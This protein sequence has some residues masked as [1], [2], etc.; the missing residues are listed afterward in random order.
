MK[1]TS[2]RW[3][4]WLL[5]AVMLLT[6]IPTVAVT[7]SAASS[8]SCGTGV[9]YTLDDAGL[10]TISGAGTVSGTIFQHNT[11]IKRIVIKSGV[12]GI[13][14]RVFLGC[15]NLETV[16]IPASV[17]T[18]GLRAFDLEGGSKLKAVN[19]AGNANLTIAG[20]AFE[21]IAS[22]YTVTYLNTL[23]PQFVGTN[24]FGSNATVYLRTDYDGTSFS[25]ATVKKLGKADAL[26]YVKFSNMYVVYYD[27]LTA[28]SAAVEASAENVEVQA[29]AGKV[30][31]AANDG[32]GKTS[33]VTVSGS[34]YDLP[35]PADCGFTAP[36]G[37]QFRGWADGSVDGNVRQVGFELAYLNSNG[38]ILYALWSAPVL[39]VTMGGST[40]NYMSFVDAFA[41]VNGKIATITL[42]QDNYNLYDE[43]E[44]PYLTSSASKITLDLNGKTLTYVDKVSGVWTSR[45]PAFAGTVLIKNGTITAENRNMAV[46]N[47]SSYAC[48]MTI[49]GD[50]TITTTNQ[51]AR[52]VGV[53]KNMTLIV[54]DGAT[55]TSNNRDSGFPGTICVYEGGK[56]ILNGGTVINNGSTP[57]IASYKSQSTDTTVVINGGTVAKMKVSDAYFNVAHTAAVTGNAWYKLT[58]GIPAAT[59]SVALGENTTTYDGTTYGKADSTV[60]L[61]VTPASGMTVSKVLAN[62]TEAAFAEGAYSFTMPKAPVTLTAEASVATVYTVTWKIGATTVAETQVKAGETITPPASLNVPVPANYYGWKWAEAQ[63]AGNGDWVSTIPDVMP[64]EPITVA[65]IWTVK[66]TLIDPDGNDVYLIGKGL[67]PE[68]CA[69]GD[70]IYANYYAEYNKT[71]HTFWLVNENNPTERYQ[72]TYYAG[73]PQWPT[74]PM[75][76]NKTFRGTFIPNEYT[77]TVSNA[78]GGAVTANGKTGSFSAA[79]GS[80]VT[81]A[82]TPATGYGFVD[83]TV[84]DSLDQPITVTGGKFTMPADDVTVTAVFAPSSATAYKILTYTM[85]LDGQYGAPTVENKTG[86]TNALITITPTAPEGFA[87]DAASVLS[88][89]VAADGSLELKVYLSRRQYVFKTVVDGVETPVTYYYGA[90][91]AKPA[92][93]A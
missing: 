47:Y 17:E 62:S 55:L 57:A 67:T 90:P 61:T 78:L 31:L 40:T 49:A 76:Q 29:V 21:N 71:G 50:V 66:L 41:A 34:T 91:V 42:L 75:D 26:T 93:P 87:V 86:T 64:A 70:T 10:L 14:N 80:E 65:G 8:G 32:T 19:L 28:A 13:D 83:Y 56:V 35:A 63:K 72:L 44:R 59:A 89:T 37:T 51:D 43:S 15:S 68:I 4:A 6:M 25:G 48:T 53:G 45:N 16:D 52:A 38:R 22:N 33:V 58:N 74:I 73:M 85:G 11:D 1:N 46:S 84:T 60:K 81:L 7:A 12:T 39:A 9:T 88:G 24:A 82:A 30:I 36:A 54:E 92:D 23:Q 5:T 77:V 79:C 3:L 27:S 2:K 18:I 69:V 20:A